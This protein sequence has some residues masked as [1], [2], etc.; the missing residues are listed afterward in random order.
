MNTS[1][2]SPEKVRDELRPLLPHRAITKIAKSV[3]LSRVMVSRVL[4]GHEYNEDVIRA[5]I[6]MVKGSVEL[7]QEFEELKKQAS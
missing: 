3:G 4:N 5:A 7:S 2:L 1:I 6:E